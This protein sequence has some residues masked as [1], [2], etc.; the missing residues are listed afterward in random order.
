MILQIIDKMT[1]N[2]ELMDKWKVL[3]ERLKTEYGID[4]NTDSILYLIG[5]QELGRG[6]E[7][8]SKEEKMDLISM[9]K[10]KLLSKIG[11]FKEKGRDEAGWII[12][13]KAENYEEMII[14]NKNKALQDLILDYFEENEFLA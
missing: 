12:F 13:E 4:S 11:L 5:I 7:D 2:R 8:F 9:A 10:A 3:N 6:F 14:D 1:L